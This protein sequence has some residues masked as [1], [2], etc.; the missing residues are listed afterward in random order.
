MY[1]RL[2][3][4]LEKAENGKRGHILYHKRI[5]KA[6]GWMTPCKQYITY[7]EN[8]INAEHFNTSLKIIMENT[9]KLWLNG[10]TIKLKNMLTI[11]MKRVR[12]NLN[13]SLKTYYYQ[14][15][16][17]QTSYGHWKFLLSLH[18]GK[19][20]SVQD[21]T[22]SGLLAVRIFRSNEIFCLI[23]SSIETDQGNSPRSNSTIEKKIRRKISFDRKI[24]INGRMP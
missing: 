7:I 15:I 13:Q 10:Y 18:S 23:F 21:A 8:N 2:R 9:A 6:N 16:S 11:K 17:I 3:Y 19:E 22:K 4:P 14:F 1:G 5:N 24:P 12:V 20:K